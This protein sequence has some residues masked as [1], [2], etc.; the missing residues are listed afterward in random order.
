MCIQ[1][2]RR[3]WGGGTTSSFW[4][5]PQTKPLQS[6]SV[7][8]S[9]QTQTKCT[10][11]QNKAAANQRLHHAATQQPQHPI[12]ERKQKKYHR[13]VWSITSKQRKNKLGEFLNSLL[14][15]K[16][17]TFQTDSH[18]EDTSEQR[19]PQT[20]INGGEALRSD[21]IYW[22]NSDFCL[23]LLHFLS[24]FVIFSCDDEIS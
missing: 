9:T 17:T 18:K 23:H 16:Y 14:V 1:N 3:K 11:P 7:F 15:C 2:Q 4:W 6:S 24:V 5:K 10:K 8:S 19:G 13:N 21:S 20:S 12:I 22:F